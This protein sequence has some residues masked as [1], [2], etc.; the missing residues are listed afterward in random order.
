MDYADFAPAAQGEELYD[1]L[2]SIEMIDHLCS[3]AQA[4]QGLAVQIYRK[5]FERCATFVKPGDC[6]GFQAILRTFV[7]RPTS[8]SRAA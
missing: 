8:S 6:F 5:Y 1:A 3:P 4:N 2:I 7:S